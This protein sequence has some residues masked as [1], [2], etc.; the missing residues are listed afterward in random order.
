MNSP[1]YLFITLASWIHFPSSTYKKW[2]IIFLI[3][4]YNHTSVTITMPLSVLL[5]HQ[6]HCKKKIT[7]K[8]LSHRK[9]GENCCPNLPPNVVVHG[10]RSTTLKLGLMSKSTWRWSTYDLSFS[11][12]KILH[13][14]FFL[15]FSLLYKPWGFCANGPWPCPLLGKLVFLYSLFMVCNLCLTYWCISWI[16]STKFIKFITS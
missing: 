8:L 10:W 7:H 9:L 14:S 11:T 13:G 12:F 5:Q 4:V 16:L 1:P 6:E 2:E 15:G 3:F